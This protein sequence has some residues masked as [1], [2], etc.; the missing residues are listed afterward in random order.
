[1]VKLAAGEVISVPRHVRV[2]TMQLAMRADALAPRPFT[3]AIPAVTVATALILRTPLVALLDRLV[4]LLP[5]GPDEDAREAGRFAF[6][7]EAV[8][9][10]GRRARGVIEGTD[11]YGVTAVIAVEGVRRLI[12]DG[13][14]PG[15]L[16]PAQAFDASDFLAVLAPYGV[17]WSLQVDDG[18]EQTARVAA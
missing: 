4:G 8:G 2:Q 18:A 10:D 17:R 14:Q 9:E 7:A 6:V 5:E 15:V 12:D 13:A 3:F 11:I 1:M 16:A